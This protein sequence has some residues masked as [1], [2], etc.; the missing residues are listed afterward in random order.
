MTYP[1]RMNILII[2]SFP[3]NFLDSLR[4][5]PVRV[6]YIPQ[7][8]RE[9]VMELI[10]EYEVLILNS[11]VNVDRA[12][13][14]KAQRLKLVIR[15]GVGMDHIDEEYLKSK[16]IQAVNTM[17]GNADSVGEHAIGMLLTLQ[18]N[19]R[20]A[21]HQLRQFQWIRPENRGRE[22]GGKTI[23]IIGY[24]NTGKAF[25]RKISGFGANIIA[26]DK[27]V[28]G[29]GNQSVRE[30]DLEEIFALS[31]IL[32]LHIPLTEETHNWIDETFLSRF[33][34]P[35]VLLNLSRGPV[36][37]LPSL[38]KAL[39]EKRVLAAGIDVFENEKL[40]T[41]TAKQRA[42]YEDLFSRD[43]VVVTPHIGGWSFESR[44][45]INQMILNHVQ[46]L[47]TKESDNS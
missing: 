18:H 23:G 43:N 38:L 27:Y 31:D 24:G 21:D 10:P 20:R 41:L 26:Y 2:D 19:I 6:K 44:E 40:D 5:M 34:K 3:Q 37:H 22:V 36:L 15:A 14:D 13:A 11:K 42:D 35:I 33:A 8:H 7:T 46:R 29:F 47:L 4:E 12:L 45:N 1:I 17:G 32:T 39:D 16:G 28:H 9:E 25:A 30:V